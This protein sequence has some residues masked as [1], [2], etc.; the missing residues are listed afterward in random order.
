MGKSA[1]RSVGMNDR[2]NK[3]LIECHKISPVLVIDDHVRQADERTPVFIDCVGDAITC[4]RNQ[5]VAYVRAVDRSNANP[6]F[7]ALS[8]ETLRS[9]EPC[10]TVGL[11]FAAKKL[12]ASA[13][14]FVFV[15]A[16]LFSSFFQNARHTFG[17]PRRQ[18]LEAFVAKCK[19]RHGRVDG[20]VESAL[21][22][23]TRIVSAEFR[24][25]E[26]PRR[27]EVGDRDRSAFLGRSLQK[28]ARSQSIARPSRERLNQTCRRN[29][30]GRTR[31]YA[32]WH[33]LYF[34]PLP[35]GQGSLRPTLASARCTGAGAAA[36]SSPRFSVSLAC[37]RETTGGGA[38][39]GGS[40]S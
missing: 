5:K 40:A 26:A 24:L 12:L 13:Q 32:P 15:L 17:S 11:T 35:Q 1:R 2:F 19:V 3:R 38:G 36:G 27:A 21:D 30:F 14:L 25:G 4:W 23:K 34:L 37:G 10:L 9:R 8:Q 22:E 39:D 33:F 28:A 20:R 16:H 31:R 7:P 29:R 18:S 6:N